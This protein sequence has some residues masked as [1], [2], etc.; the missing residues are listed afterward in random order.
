MIR[1]NERRIDTREVK[2]ENVSP[3]CRN[4][5][6][7]LDH[8][9]LRI[10]FE[11]SHDRQTLIRQPLKQEHYRRI[12]VLRRVGSEISTNPSKGFEMSERKTFDI[13]N[14]VEGLNRVYAAVWS[15]D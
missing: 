7:N 8:D 1:S 15:K 13:G 3:Q 14:E 10:S 12:R 11:H 6:C 2:P 9:I 4:R 5:D